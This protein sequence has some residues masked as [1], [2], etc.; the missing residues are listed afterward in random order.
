MEMFRPEN[1]SKSAEHQRIYALFEVWYTAVDFTAAFSFIIGSVLFFWKS[2]QVPATWLFV[3]GSIC[4]ALKPTIRL[5]RELKY[6][7]MGDYSDLV[8]RDRGQA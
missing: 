5:M 6:L 8:Q 4:F 7:R 2:T 1:R 3:I